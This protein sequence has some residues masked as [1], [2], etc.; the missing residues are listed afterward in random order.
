MPENEIPVALLIVASKPHSPLDGIENSVATRVKARHM[1]AA[2]TPPVEP[3]S[4]AKR[5]KARCHV[6]AN[7]TIQQLI[8]MV[9]DMETGDLMDY[10]TLL[11]HPK[12]KDA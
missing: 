11:H 7:T 8:H 6:P 10:H 3:Q 4:I 1:A 5:V 12:F 2:G 9:V